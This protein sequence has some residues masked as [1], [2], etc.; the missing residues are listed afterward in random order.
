MLGTDLER[1]G[2]VSWQ[3]ALISL[4]AFWVAM[5][6]VIDAPWNYLLV[7]SFVKGAGAVFVINQFWCSLVISR[8]MLHSLGSSSSRSSW[9]CRR[10]ELRYRAILQ[11]ETVC[12][13]TRL[14]WRRPRGVCLPEVPS[15]GAERVCAQLALNVS[16]CWPMQVLLQ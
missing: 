1:W 12:C 14:F 6:G 16:L 9:R 7:R 11:L 2:P 15:R 13:E 3:S 8:S 5:A 4:G 10:D